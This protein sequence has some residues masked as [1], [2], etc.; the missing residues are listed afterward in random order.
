MTATMC[1]KT[2]LL[3]ALLLPLSGPVPSDPSVP[4]FDASAVIVA[5]LYNFGKFVDWPDNAFSEDGATLRFCNY[6]DNIPLA[7]V[8]TLHGK[9][10]ENRAITV[11]QI[12]RGGS[13]TACHVL[14]IGRSE[15]LYLKPILNVTASLPILTVSDI[16][17]FTDAGGVIG[18]V[19]DGNRM[20]FEINSGAAT[21]ARLHISSQLFKLATRV[22]AQ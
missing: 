13:L 8:Q 1:V 5:Y 18:L 11:E 20:R 22:V 6:G 14:F 4:A 21:E 7:K 3:L 10:I 15:R 17:H 16:E 12:D 9:Q 2:R 19:S